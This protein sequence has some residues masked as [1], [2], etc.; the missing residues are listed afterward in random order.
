MKRRSE[1]DD[2]YKFH[3]A[4]E[5]GDVSKVQEL[6]ERGL[7]DVN[8]RDEIGYTALHNAAEKGHRSARRRLLNIIDGTWAASDGWR[9]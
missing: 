4:C 9:P 3:R 8:V 7:D 6:I 5:D 1:L 2:L